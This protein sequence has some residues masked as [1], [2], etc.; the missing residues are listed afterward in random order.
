MKLSILVH[1]SNGELLVVDG[2]E[3]L[4]YSNDHKEI[5]SLCLYKAEEVCAAFA[6]FYEQG[7]QQR[8][9]FDA[10]E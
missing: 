2:A 7:I 8:T 3:L 6:K 4:K 9:V 10:K 1:E 5:S